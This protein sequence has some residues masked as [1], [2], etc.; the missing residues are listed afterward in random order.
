MRVIGQNVRLPDKCGCGTDLVTVGPGGG[1]F[2]AT[3]VCPQC[4]C[5]RGALTEFTLHLIE[6]IASKFG[7]PAAITIRRY[8]KPLEEKCAE[9]DEV[10]KRKRAPSGKTFFEI[11]TE[12]SFT[13]SG[14]DAEEDHPP[15]AENQSSMEKTN[16]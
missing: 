1:K 16:D 2:A 13:P 15:G 7:V 3:L 11:I 8:V 10:L 4:G 6:S 14:T 12:T 9:H 5:D